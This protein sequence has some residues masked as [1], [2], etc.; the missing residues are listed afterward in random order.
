M[1]GYYFLSTNFFHFDFAAKA[2]E[3]EKTMSLLSTH[4]LVS[5]E[6]LSFCDNVLLD[7]LSSTLKSA[8]RRMFEYYR[9]KLWQ[10]YEDAWDAVTCDTSKVSR[11]VNADGYEMNSHVVHRS[12]VC[13]AI[14]ENRSESVNCSEL[15]TSKRM[16]NDKSKMV[17]D[18]QLSERLYQISA[19]SVDTSGKTETACTVEKLP[20]CYGDTTRVPRYGSQL[21]S[22]GASTHFLRSSS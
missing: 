22:K 4:G 17:S 18:L 1:T 7:E 12:D 8:P 10:P 6:Y 5:G 14:S 3:V 20:T 9:I 13:P 11:A 15:R 19:S 16:G 2:I 21:N